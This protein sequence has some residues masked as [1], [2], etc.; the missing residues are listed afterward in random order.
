[1]KQIRI[2]TKLQKLIKEASKAAKM[3]EQLLIERLL[4]IGCQRVIEH[5]E[6]KPEPRPTKK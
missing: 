3:S 5:Q 6:Q 1:M 4:L 2:D